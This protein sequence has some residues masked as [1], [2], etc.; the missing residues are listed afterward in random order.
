MFI[1]FWGSARAGHALLPSMWVSVM[2]SLVF[3]NEAFLYF[4][5]HHRHFANFQTS[6]TFQTVPGVVV[7]V[8]VVVMV[9]G[10]IVV[11][12]LCDR[13]D[14]DFCGDGQCGGGGHYDGGLDCLDRRTVQYCST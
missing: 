11:V 3:T 4:L 7:V 14:K 8:V 6:Q 13:G 12:V 5:M 1:S 10:F 2:A 9:M